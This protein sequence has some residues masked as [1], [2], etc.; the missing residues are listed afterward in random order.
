[1]AVDTR[2]LNQNSRPRSNM[3]TEKAATRMV[4][5]TATTEN[6]ATRRPCSRDP[7]L[8]FL[9]SLH[10]LA[11]R[12]RKSVVE[13]KRVSVRVDPGGRRR[14]QKKTTNTDQNKEGSPQ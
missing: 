1:M 7:A 10:R 11:R 8:P 14:I 3:M 9:R 5:A 2:S 13:G 12:D 6:N 4:G